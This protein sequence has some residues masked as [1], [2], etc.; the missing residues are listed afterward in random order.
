[1][2]VAHADVD[3]Q[4]H[5][6]RAQRCFQRRRLLHRQLGQRRHAAEPLVVM[7]DLVDPLRTDATSAQ[8][9]L[10]KRPHVVGSLGTAECDK[11]HGVEGLHRRFIVRASSPSSSGARSVLWNGS[12]PVATLLLYLAF[13][14]VPDSRHQRRRR[15][16]RRHSRACRRAARAWRRARRRA[17]R[18]SERD[19]P[20]ADAAPAA[21]D[22]AAARRRL[23]SRRHADRLRQHRH[24]Q[25]LHRA[26]AI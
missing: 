11:Q 9:V 25:A 18:R 6:A 13:S 7:R 12:S 22:G 26:A 19:R 3:G 5:A 10:E 21:A 14:D 15:P 23:R 20:R 8:D 2:P 16:L 24:H 17:A 1:M 4:R